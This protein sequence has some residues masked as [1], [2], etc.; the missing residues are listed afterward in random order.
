[1]PISSYLTGVVFRDYVSGDF[2]SAAELQL[3]IMNQ[4]LMS[5]ESSTERDSALTGYEIE[6]MVI[7]LRDVKYPMVYD[8][9]GWVRYGRDIDIAAGDTRSSLATLFMTST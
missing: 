3:Y 6:G 8:G 4:A 2:L 1:M 9:T 5:F 7:Y